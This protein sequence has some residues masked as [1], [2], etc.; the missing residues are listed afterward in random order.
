MVNKTTKKKPL[1]YYLELQYSVTLHPDPEG[2]YVAEIKDLPG[3]I[4]QGD[5]LEE[6]MGNIS[7]AREL[8]I[9]TAYDCGDD[10]PLPSQE[11]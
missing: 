2:G 10:I 3:C 8:W 11:Q 4:T 9:E 1:E 6:A 7:E 5:T